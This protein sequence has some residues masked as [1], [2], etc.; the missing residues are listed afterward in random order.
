MPQVFHGDH[1]DTVFILEFPVFTGVIEQEI[2]LTPIV[3]HCSY[4]LVK[5]E[6]NRKV[7]APLSFSVVEGPG[8]FKTNN[9]VH[10]HLCRVK[11]AEY[12]KAATAHGNAGQFPLAR[13]TCDEGIA[14]LKESHV[15]KK[16]IVQVLMKDLEEAKER[17]VDTQSWNSGGFAQVQMM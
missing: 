3:A 10:I 9:D 12:M 14:Y 13:E 1:K 15:S 8:L 5:T 17:F 7:T 4:R 6:E 11:T 2:T 16:E